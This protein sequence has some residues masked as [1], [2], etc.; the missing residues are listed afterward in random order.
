MNV[1]TTTPTTP[2]A[3]RMAR[4]PEA[5]AMLGAYLTAGGSQVG[6]AA[7]QTLVGTPL[8]NARVTKVGQVLAMLQR[9]GGAS[10][11]DLIALTGWLPHTTRAALT[12]LRKKGSPLT[13]VKSEGGTRI[14]RIE[15]AAAEAASAEV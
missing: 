9:T 13:S 8:S 5:L 1:T 14:Y 3:R 6:G 15:A 10:L 4:E 11:E 2:R 12:G 7:D